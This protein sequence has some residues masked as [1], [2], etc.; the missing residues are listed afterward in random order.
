MTPQPSTS[1]PVRFA[2]AMGW[3]ACDIRIR[4]LPIIDSNTV[5]EAFLSLSPEDKTSVVSRLRERQKAQLFYRSAQAWH[6]DVIQSTIEEPPTTLA[7]IICEV[8]GIS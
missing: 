2:K 3:T 5:R 7:E 4:G 6:E 8:K 1:L